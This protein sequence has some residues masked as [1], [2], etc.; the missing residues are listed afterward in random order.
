MGLR[1]PG[2]HLDMTAAVRD[3]VRQ[4]IGE[5][6]E[7][8]RVSSSQVLDA[9]IVG[10]PIMHHLYLGFDPYEL[11]QA[12]FTFATSKA[13]SVA[14][15][16]VDLPIHPRAKIYLLP[17]VGNHVGADAAAVMLCE[18]LQSTEAM[19]LI[20]DI[21]TNAEFFLGNCAGIVASSSPTGPALEGARNRGHLPPHLPRVE[22]VI[23]PAST[24]CIC[25]CGE[26]AKIG[27]DVSERLDV[28]PAQFRVLVTRRPKYAC[29]RC[30]QV[31]AQAHATQHVV[32]D[33]LPSELFVAWI[34]VSKFG[35]HLPF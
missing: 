33:G 32:P 27:E 4:L 6:T 15:R 23:E 29:R 3:G 31:V 30:S 9:V 12:P 13:L 20:I 35:D 28:I 10:N 24:Q 19:T 7:K 11:G 18:S 22:R 17:A 2:T 1:S 21:G 16:D 14:A 5:L 8:F 25:G 26:M 34:I